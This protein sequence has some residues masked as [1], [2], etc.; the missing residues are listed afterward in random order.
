MLK[1]NVHIFSLNVQA[2]DLGFF[3]VKVVGNHY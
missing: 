2:V 1:M 3:E